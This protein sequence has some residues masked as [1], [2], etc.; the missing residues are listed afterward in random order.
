MRLA[1]RA[2]MAAV[3]ACGDKTTDPLVGQAE[4]PTL[5]PGQQ[6]TATERGSC[7]K[8]YW[9]NLV[10]IFR[11]D[12]DNVR[13]TE[14]PFHSAFFKAWL[15]RVCFGPWQGKDLLVAMG[16]CNI[17][18]GQTWTDPKRK[19]SLLDLTEYPSAGLFRMWRPVEY[20]GW[21]MTRPRE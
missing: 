7:G 13:E 19:M 3:A 20:F 16:T 11:L 4:T 8:I 14:T 18:N 1:T 15:D 9:S 6:S 2:L 21:N 10:P 17:S 12:L 5:E